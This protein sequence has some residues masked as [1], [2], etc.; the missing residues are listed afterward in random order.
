MS[1]TTETA[2]L[3]AL[4]NAATAHTG[5]T[6]I[7][8]IPDAKGNVIRNEIVGDGDDGGDYTR[9]YSA[10]FITADGDRYDASFTEWWYYANPGPVPSAVRVTKVE[11][12][13]TE[14]AT[15]IGR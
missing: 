2:A 6:D 8:V 13:D 1:K 10:Q 14:L 5:A 9:E 11:L 4:T 7:V 12:D 15:F 3:L